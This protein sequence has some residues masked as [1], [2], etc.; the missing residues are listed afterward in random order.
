VVGRT[1]VGKVDELDV[2][3]T[4]LADSSRAI[5]LA[6]ERLECKTACEGL[7]LGCS[8]DGPEIRRSAMETSD[9]GERENVKSPFTG[10]LS[11]DISRSCVMKPV[12]DGVKEHEMVFLK[13]PY[14]VRLVHNRWH[15]RLLCGLLQEILVR[16]F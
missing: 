11:D 6:R 1:L 2:G 15:L 8:E 13:L 7:G 16:A 3:M 9:A 10:M 4:G 12:R 14:L 5:K